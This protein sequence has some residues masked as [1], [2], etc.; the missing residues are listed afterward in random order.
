MK[1]LPHELSI[2][3]TDRLENKE[4][5]TARMGQKLQPFVARA[6]GSCYKQIKE[7]KKSDYLRHIRLMAGPGNAT[8]IAY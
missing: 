1:V 6:T 8:L 4:F 5:V 7:R 2:I 3:L